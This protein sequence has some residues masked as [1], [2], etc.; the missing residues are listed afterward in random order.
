[1]PHFCHIFCHTIFPPTS[2]SKKFDFFHLDDSDSFR[3]KE[4]E[5]PEI[6]VSCRIIPI[7]SGGNALVGGVVPGVLS[8]PY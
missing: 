2:N 8:F 7:S 5:E 3:R 6:S 4:S 1:M